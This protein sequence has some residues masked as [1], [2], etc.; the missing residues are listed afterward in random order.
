MQKLKSTNLNKALKKKI[1]QAV[2]KGISKDEFLK[3]N[4][5]KKEATYS[6]E[7]Y[8][9]Y[10]KLRQQKKDEHIDTTE[11]L[12]DTMSESESSSII[13]ERDLQDLNYQENA[14][15]ESVIKDEEVLPEVFDEAVLQ[16]ENYILRQEIKYLKRINKAKNKLIK[17][18]KGWKTVDQTP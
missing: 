3:T 11:A 2:A 16:M 17:A 9:N 10:Q 8:F 1:S 15:E 14:N 5:I 4:K 18:L 13:P 6:A 12:P 7:A